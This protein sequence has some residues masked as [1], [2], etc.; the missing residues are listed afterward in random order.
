MLPRPDTA[1]APLRDVRCNLVSETRRRHVSLSDF[2]PARAK[3]SSPCGE[4]VES[5]DVPFPPSA[6][7]AHSK[8]HAGGMASPRDRECCCVFEESGDARDLLCAVGPARLSWRRAR[9][10]QSK[11]H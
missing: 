10:H 8:A 3:P 5:I 7:A 2:F 4:I 1:P 6:L 11:M 9:T